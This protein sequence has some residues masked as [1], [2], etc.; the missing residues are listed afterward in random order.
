MRMYAPSPGENPMTRRMMYLV[1]WGFTT[2]ALGLGGVLGGYT[3]DY[4]MWVLFTAVGG[5][6]LLVPLVHR[7][8][9]WTDDLAFTLLVAV[10][11]GRAVWTVWRTI[12]YTR[13]AYALVTLLAVV[14]IGAAFSHYII[15]GWPD[16]S[17]SIRWRSGRR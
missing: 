9:K 16:T 12:L 17:W 6:C 2:F 7:W 1:T 10:Y 3:Y 11:A 14:F 4:S 13:S 5:Y 15:A 8:F